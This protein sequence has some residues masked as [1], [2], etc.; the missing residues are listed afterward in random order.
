MYPQVKPALRRLWRD[1][2]T[3]QLGVDPG[4]AVVLQGVTPEI[5][6][7]L[8]E[9]DGTADG[10]TALQRAAARGVDQQVALD[11]IDCLARHD[12]LADGAVGSAQRPGSDAIDRERLAPDLAALSLSHPGLGA[13]QAVLDR[14]TEATVT[15]DGNG[16]VGSAVVAL[17]AAAGVGRVVPLDPRPLRGGDLGPAGAGC[18][19]LGLR[20]G[21]A[22]V[23]AARRTAPAVQVGPGD[24]GPNEGRSLTVLAPDSVVDPIRRDRLSRAGRAHLP[25]TIID[26]GGL[27]G[28]LVVPAET[29]CLACVEQHHTDRDPAW[30]VLLAQ[31]TAEAPAASTCDVTL[32]TMLAAVA[33]RMVL[34][35]LDGVRPEPGLAYGLSVGETVP[36]ARTYPFHPTCGCRWDRQA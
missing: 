5:A 34:S 3:L 8:L 16:R 29:P 15:V 6:A 11:L 23:A 36:R 22:A 25:V 2:S 9:L 20:R 31:L 7:F 33:C 26:G 30:P 27:V 17:L 18:A 32:A 19:E 24:P 12:A 1:R 4:R 28:P 21:E 10:P 14:R 13:A 35:C